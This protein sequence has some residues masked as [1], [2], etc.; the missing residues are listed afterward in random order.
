MKKYRGILIVNKFLNNSK[1]S[2]I[3]A[4]FMASAERMGAELSLFTNDE[5]L[6]AIDDG[7]DVMPEGTAPCKA[8]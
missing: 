8:A 6:L 7:L 4:R 3:S 2:D 5:I 1:F